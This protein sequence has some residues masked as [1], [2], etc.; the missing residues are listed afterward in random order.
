MTRTTGVFLVLLVGLV[1]LALLAGCTNPIPRS[2]PP[3]LA[4]WA[5]KKAERLGQCYVDGH[6]GR[7]LIACLGEYAPNRG[8][9]ACE[10]AATMAAE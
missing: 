2:L 6:R 5:E 1:L 8:T 9:Y 4:S 3:I 10:R 7:E